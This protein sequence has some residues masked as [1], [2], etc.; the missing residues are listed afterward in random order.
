VPTTTT[1]TTTQAPITEAQAEFI[2]IPVITNHTR[3]TDIITTNQS[4]AFLAPRGKIVLCFVLFLCELQDFCICLILL[5]SEIVIPTTTTTTTQAPTTTT[6]EPPQFVFVPVIVSSFD[7]FMTYSF[8]GR[9]SYF[10][11]FTNL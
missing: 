2:Y 11:D 9:H 3:I 10:S 4:Q 8:F 7:F 5:F 1:T 6:E